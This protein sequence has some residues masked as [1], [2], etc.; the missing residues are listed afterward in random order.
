[1]LVYITLKLR[2]VSAIVKKSQQSQRDE[3]FRSYNITQTI[4]GVSS[5]TADLLG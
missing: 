1:M 4:R 3:K 5:D 2:H